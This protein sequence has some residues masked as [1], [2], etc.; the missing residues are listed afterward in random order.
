MLTIVNILKLAWQWPRSK[1]DTNY[2]FRLWLKVYE[3]YSYT[4]GHFG[5]L[6]EQDGYFE[7]K[8]LQLYLYIIW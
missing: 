1:G 6:Y 4:S 2:Q 7:I 8:L 3:I 5:I